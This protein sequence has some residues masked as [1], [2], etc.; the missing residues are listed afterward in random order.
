MELMGLAMQVARG[1]TSAHAAGIIH[2]DL[3]PENLLIERDTNIVRIADFGL[4]KRDSSS[5]L[6]H[7]D[8][9]AGTPAYMSPEQTLGQ[10]LDVGSDLFSL[11]SVLRFAATGAPPFG[12]EDTDVVLHRIRTQ[13]LEPLHR[14]RPDLPKFMCEAFDRLL[15]KNSKQRTA[16]AADFLKQLAN[17][18]E[19]KRVWSLAEILATSIGVLILLTVAGLWMNAYYADGSKDRF[20][21][22]RITASDGEKPTNQ[23][24]QELPFGILG[25]DRFRTLAEAIRSAKDGQSII[26]EGNGPYESPRIDISHKRLSI[27]AGENASPL[28]VPKKGPISS[29]QQ[30]LISDRELLIKG[31]RIDWPIE[32]ELTDFQKLYEMPAVFCNG[33]L[34]TL[35]GCDIRRGATGL[36]AYGARSILIK[37]CKLSGGSHCIGWTDFGDK[38]TVNDTTLDSKGGLLLF[39]APANI[40]PNRAGEIHLTNSSFAGESSVEIMFSRI[41]SKPFHVHAENCKFSSRALVSLIS[42]PVTSNQAT[43]PRSMITLMQG[44]MTWQETNCSHLAGQS[45]LSSRILKRPERRY[46]SEIDSLEAWQKLWNTE[47]AGSYESR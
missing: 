44:G 13:P 23:E 3:K 4:A 14:L 35:E 5:L 1:L 34:L 45:Y 2:R 17:S 30:F 9:V 20:E 31:L 32:I 41:Q 25:G 38:V 10:A 43:N 42:T 16:S 24:L 37:D 19:S 8:V 40:A 7:P 21:N 27:V 26:V 33:D 6:T 18:T 39:Y 28:F 47:F 36:S 15:T 22:Q 11:G 12:A 46:P 29:N